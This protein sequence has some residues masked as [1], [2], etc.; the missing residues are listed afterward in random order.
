[1]CLIPAL[2][3]AETNPAVDEDGVTKH[4]CDV[5]TD[6]DDTQDPEKGSLRHRLE[7]FNQGLDEDGNLTENGKC[8]SGIYFLES[9]T[10]DLEGSL[11][12]K[13]I[14]TQTSELWLGTYISGADSNAEP[15]PV[16][17]DARAINSKRQC[18]IIIEGGLSTFQQIHDL[19]LLVTDEEKAICDGEGNNL[20]NEKIPNN[21]SRDCKSGAL[22]KDC[23]FKNVEIEVDDSYINFHSLA[24]QNIKAPQSSQNWKPIKEEEEENPT[25]S[26]QNDKPVIILN[27]NDLLTPLQEK[28]TEEP[29]QPEAEEEPTP[30]PLASSFSKPMSCSF[31]I[32]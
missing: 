10:I 15:L 25:E 17:I 19:T 14:E 4:I 26:G 9:M 23:D 28:N 27:K 1:M 13:P 21:S 5:R 7:L 20:L 11:V 6:T 29:E 16:I 30:D 2:L 24:S 31:I 22:A 3:K 8:V 18:A 12:I 32:F